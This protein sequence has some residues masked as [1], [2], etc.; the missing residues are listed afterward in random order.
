MDARRLREVLAA[1]IR[2][3]AR[4]RGVPLNAVADFAGVARSQLYSVLAGEKSA[5]TDWLAK[6]ANALEVEPWRLLVPP[7]TRTQKGA[8][9]G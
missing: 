2:A 8:P 3:V 4:E 9:D 7:D 5:T 1:N 6:V